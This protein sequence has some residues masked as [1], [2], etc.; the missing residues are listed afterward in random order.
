MLSKETPTIAQPQQSMNH[1][2]IFFQCNVPFFPP[3]IET[4][5]LT[6]N[7]TPVIKYQLTLQWGH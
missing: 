5:L 3:C 2:Q 6:L 4:T 7:E 1:V